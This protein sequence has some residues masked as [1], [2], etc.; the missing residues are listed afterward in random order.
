MSDRIV[1]LDARDRARSDL[2]RVFTELRMV[3]AEHG[4]KPPKAIVVDHDT[5]NAFEF[6]NDLPPVGQDPYFLGI[7]IRGER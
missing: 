4:L 3:F 2:S 7:E 6:L 5:R 1:N